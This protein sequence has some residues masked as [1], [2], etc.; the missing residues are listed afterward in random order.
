M[1]FSNWRATTDGWFRERIAKESVTFETRKR[2]ELLD[3]WDQKVEA[4][5]LYMA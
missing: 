4:L 2:E 1:I 5:K 3:G